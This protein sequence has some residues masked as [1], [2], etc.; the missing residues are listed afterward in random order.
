MSFYSSK[1]AGD[2]RDLLLPTIQPPRVGKAHL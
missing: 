1:A 2:I